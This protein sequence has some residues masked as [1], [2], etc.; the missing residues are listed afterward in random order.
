MDLDQATDQFFDY[1]LTTMTGVPT[2]L[3]AALR[4]TLRP[5]FSVT[6][7][8]RNAVEL[9]YRNRDV[10]PVACLNHGANLAD[11]AAQMVAELSADRRGARISDAIRKMPGVAQRVAAPTTDPEPLPESLTPAGPAP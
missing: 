2:A 1:A 9:I 4:A 8:A 5:K 11:A 7:V 3:K 6:L 10:L